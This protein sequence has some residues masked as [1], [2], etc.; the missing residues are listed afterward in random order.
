MSWR[1]SQTTLN[2]T[3]IPAQI[4]IDPERR[5]MYDEL[6]GFSDNSVNPFMDD[7]FQRDQVFVD[8][9]SCIGCRNCNNVAPRTFEME[10]DWGRA[11]AMYQEA[12][13]PAKLQEAIDTCPVS[14]IHWVRTLPSTP[15]CLVT[16]SFAIDTCP[17]SCINWVRAWS[18][19]T[20]LL[21]SHG[22]L[23]SLIGCCLAGLLMGRLQTDSGSDICDKPY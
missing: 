17:V 8:E 12:D 18:L 23:S 11:R 21:C 6:A 15:A 5:A 22:A 16:A 13:T 20:L 19:K 7:S 4:L 9:F 2:L 1:N 14:C 10:D 3:L